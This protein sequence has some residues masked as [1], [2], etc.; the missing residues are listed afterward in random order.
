M[1]IKSGDSYIRF[2]QSDMDD[3]ELVIDNVFVQ[4]IERGRGIGRS[5]VSS[6]IQYAEEN[7]YATIGLYAEPQS[8][9]G[10][11]GDSLIEFYSSMGFRS[12]SDDNQ[13]MTYRV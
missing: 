13:L 8:N 12:D 1:E 6:V 2:S 5:L 10:L 9:D 4:K 3:N 7:D 11:D